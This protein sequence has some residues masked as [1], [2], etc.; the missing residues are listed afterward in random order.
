MVAFTVMSLAAMRLG[1]LEAAE[2]PVAPKFVEKFDKSV[3]LPGID[4]V[5]SAVF[6]DECLMVGGCFSSFINTFRKDKKTGKLT[7][8]EAIKASEPLWK[9][10]PSVAG[11]H[12]FFHMASGSNNVFYTTG[13]T[14]HADANNRSM[15]MAWYRIDPTTGKSALLGNQKCHAGNLAMCPQNKQCLYL[16][17]QFPPAIETYRIRGDGTPVKAETITEKGLGSLEIGRASCRE[18]VWRYV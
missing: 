4:V 5:S 8:I 10:N 17:T 18:R 6:H 15:G 14:F 11:Q 2:S 13:T 16:I 12:T 1:G 9:N 7:Y 3:E